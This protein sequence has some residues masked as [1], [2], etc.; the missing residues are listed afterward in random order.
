M[1]SPSWLQ[2]VVKNTSSL[3]L[4]L[5]TLEHRERQRQIAR[6]TQDSF[7]S[8]TS[9][10][11][12]G[13]VDSSC[14]VPAVI[15][16]HY[17]CVIGQLPANKHKNRYIDLEP[18]DR[19]RVKVPSNNK[20]EQ[21]ETEDGRYI[22]ANWVRELWGGKVWIAAQAPLP[23]TFHAFLTLCMVPAAPLR[24]QQRVHTIVQLTMPVENGRRR[25]HQY[26]STQ[27]GSAV[28][29]HPEQGCDTLPSIHVRVESE[30]HVDN[31]GC[32]LTDLR[33]RWYDRQQQELQT[34]EEFQVTHLLY[35]GWPDFGVPDENESILNFVRL[36]ER[37]NNR[38]LDAIANHDPNDSPPILIHCSAGVGRTGSLIALFSILRAYSLLTSHRPASNPSFPPSLTQSPLGPLP[39][40]LKN[41]LVVQ[42]IDAL[43]EQR[44]GMV[45]RD[46]QAA[47]IY[48]ALIDAFNGYKDVLSSTYFI[49]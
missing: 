41:D 21:G 15:R 22:N 23:N 40:K 13:S 3:S 25:A 11:T 19:T 5:H 48:Y 1:A 28:V 38:H 10:S 24:R 16:A 37:V 26:F 30:E 17:S 7:L 33:L 14:G 31:A 32:I 29:I 34:T 42:E 45:Q 18:Y 39:S 46:E 4:A 9:D 43:R 2:S 27:V 20:E 8:S 35:T 49:R 12:A 6:L 36:V 44:Q 47:W